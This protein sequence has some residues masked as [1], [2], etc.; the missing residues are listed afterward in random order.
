MNIARSKIVVAG[1]VLCIAT[2]TQADD[3]VFQFGSKKAIRGTLGKMTKNFVEIKPR[4]GPAQKVPV[5]TIRRVRFN[6]ESPQLNLARS[7]EESGLLTRALESYTGLV[8]SLKSAAK[9]DT[10]FLIARTKCRLAVV[11]ATKV[12]DAIKSMKA[13]LAKNSDGFRHYECIL[14]LGRVEVAR[15]DFP[16]ARS[17]FDQLAKSTMKS[18]QMLAKVATGDVLLLQNKPAEAQASYDQVVSMPAESPSEIASRFEAVLGRAKCARLQKNF[19]EA[20]K[21]LD[22]IIDNTDPREGS[23][24]HA[25]AYVQKGD[26]YRD[27]Q[28]AKMAV[29]S[30]LHVDVIEEYRRA[31]DAHAEAL[32][33][34]SQLWPAAGR[35]NRGAE[36]AA[37][38]K[39]LYPNNPWTKKQA[40]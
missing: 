39:K 9:T 37:K 32:F 34:L 25:R 15:G 6:A 36:A 29:M 14:W 2:A 33:Q 23:E 40:G 21:S 38:L 35:P 10:E 27:Q 12:D 28:N 24:L 1:L 8:G 22:D 4:S 20:L 16:A 13:M 17:R 19:S 31:A 30:Y 11:D 18:H 5:D 7:N 26:C 3:Q